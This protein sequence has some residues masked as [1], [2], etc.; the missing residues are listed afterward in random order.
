MGPGKQLL[1]GV[2]LKEL[3]NSFKFDLA[4]SPST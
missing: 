1:P 3:V 2:D 4:A